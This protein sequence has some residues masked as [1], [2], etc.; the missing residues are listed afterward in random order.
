LPRQVRTL[1]GRA[2]RFRAR[3]REDFL[4]GEVVRPA[5]GSGGGLVELKVG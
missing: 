5:I 4:V 2:E 3:R 1:H